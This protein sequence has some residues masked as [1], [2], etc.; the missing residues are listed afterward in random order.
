ML[1]RN[2][3]TATRPLAWIVIAGFIGAL[4][5]LGGL[6]AVSANA[7]AVTATISD[8]ADATPCAGDI[9]SDSSCDLT[10]QLSN[11]F[12]RGT[13]WTL[14]TF[15]LDDALDASMITPGTRTLGDC[16]CEYWIPANAERTYKIQLTVGMLTEGSTSGQ[17]KVF[18][19]PRA[20]RDHTVASLAEY[21]L[22]IQIATTITINQVTNTTAELSWAGN[23]AATMAFIFWWPAADSS[24]S[25]TPIVT[26]DSS[27]TISGLQPST[28][29]AV[30][31]QP[32]R[33]ET[34]YQAKQVEVTT[35]ASAQQNT[36]CSTT[37]DYDADNDG[38]IEVCNLQQL[39]A[40]RHDLNGD[41][42]PDVYPQ[43]FRVYPAGQSPVLS[44]EYGIPLLF[45]VHYGDYTDAER[46]TLYG[47]AFPGAVA[48][49]GCP[50]DTGC[51]GFELSADLDFDTNNSGSIDPAD[52]F[53]NNG[54]GWRPI[55]GASY[56]SENDGNYG[57]TIF[58][59]S[60]LGGDATDAAFH[61][62]KRFNAVFEGNGRTID[63]LY[64]NRPQGKLVGLF[65]WAGP[66]AQIRNIGLTASNGD[67]QVTGIR[68]VGVL[69]GHLEGG[70]VSG[71]YAQ[72]DVTARSQ[73]GGG[74]IGRGSANAVLIESYA[75]GDVYGY[76]VI[77]G[78]AGVFSSTRHNEGL[79]AATFASGNVRAGWLSGGG[80]VGRI[81]ASKLYA[82]Y[83]AG[84]VTDDYADEPTNLG[85]LVGLASWQGGHKYQRATYAIGQVASVA[86]PEGVGG[87]HGS[88]DQKPLLDS[89][90]DTQTTGQ[91]RSAAGLGKTTSELQ[92]PTDYSGI[93]A[94]WDLHTPQSWRT[95]AD[96]SWVKPHD[97]LWDFGTATQYPI[98]TYCAEKSGID[99][100]WDPNRTE[101]CPLREATQHGRTYGN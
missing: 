23:M 82:S 25:A 64:I 2:K 26:T 16:P 49:M 57:Y 99:L 45:N 17:I 84:N 20:S 79:I 71:S 59:L 7:G 50:T 21:Q 56:R 90:W 31:V 58:Q 39:D 11:T 91:T 63:N 77:G 68:S 36:P 53:W 48:G 1:T 14:D 43:Q 88:D 55:I 13:L 3:Q 12:S 86:A 95:I 29:Y 97:T 65:G 6:A 8:D 44:D 69:V 101:Y 40:I 41:G 66:Q 24:D 62:V 93:F 27:Y 72:I 75:T 52:R 85:G 46:I 54:Q 19:G 18:D 81:Y 35:R 74:L 96:Q 42:V 22:E 87:L 89:Y 73:Y 30:L 15:G 28:A 98:L 32:H 76:G 33:D 83:A 60:P 38:L 34:N 78:L 10:V 100:S 37:G 4:G 92:T 51:V 67:A 94:D 61:N 5:A 70:R 9:L 47:E 80:L